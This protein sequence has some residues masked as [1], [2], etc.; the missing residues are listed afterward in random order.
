MTELVLFSD[1]RP[2]VRLLTLNRPA[3]KNAM[4]REMYGAAAKAL[5]AADHDP[6]VRVVCLTG[7][8][9]AF[10]A[11]NDI[12]DFQTA[13]PPGAK[14][15]GASTF[16]TAVARLEKP[17]VAAVNGVAVGIGTTILLHCDIVYAASGAR[18]QLPFVNLGLVPEAG[19]SM[20][21]PRL[22]GRRRAAELCLFGDGF[23][24]AT[25]RDWGL[26]NGVVPDAELLGHTL[27]RAAALAARPTRVVRLIKRL[28]TSEAPSLEARI[29][30]E[31][32]LLAEQLE[33]PEAQ[34][35][36]RAFIERRRPD[37]SR[38]P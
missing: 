8:G 32:R 29:A 7:T 25:A 3:K 13:P 1:P 35:A 6:A 36:I 22:V 38:F 16:I 26:I 5:A 27:D 12:G 18:F 19:C 28:L 33:A 21:L 24:A 20:L 31:I 30:E 10:T 15:I 34:E 23:D 17:I 11:G 37:F 2:G 4:T 14:K 9:D